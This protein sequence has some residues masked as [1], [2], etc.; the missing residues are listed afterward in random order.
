MG[1]ALSEWK[2]IVKDFSE[3]YT[4][5]FYAEQRFSLDGRKQSPT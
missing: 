1:L 2:K 5:N 4:S 3:N